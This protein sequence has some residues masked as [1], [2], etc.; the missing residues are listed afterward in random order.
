MSLGPNSLEHLVQFVAQIDDCVE[1]HP[2]MPLG[3][4]PVNHLRK[5]HSLRVTGGH[6]RTI[7]VPFPWTV[8]AEF[9][10]LWGAQF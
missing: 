3:A 8:L 10:G 6:I 5:P 2:L 7:V 4:Q 1:G 9:A